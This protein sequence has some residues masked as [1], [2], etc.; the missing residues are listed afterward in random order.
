MRPLLITLPM[1]EALVDGTR[2]FRLE[3][4]PEAPG[5]GFHV[6]KPSREKLAQAL[7]SQNTQRELVMPNPP[8]RAPRAPSLRSLVRLA[9]ACDSAEEMGKKLK[10]RFDRQQQRAG[11]DTGRP[12]AV[13]DAEIDR[14]LGPP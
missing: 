10:Q 12:S 2:Y 1:I 14:L 3:D 4:Q 9:L 6:C 13:V 8:P 11:V 7:R 5:S